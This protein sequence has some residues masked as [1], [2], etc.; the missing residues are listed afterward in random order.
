VS[1]IDSI[2]EKALLVFVLAESGTL[3]AARI[4]IQQLMIGYMNVQQSPN[5]E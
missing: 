3:G 4:S 2:C 5:L 1:P